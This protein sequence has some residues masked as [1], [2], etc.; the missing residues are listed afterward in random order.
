MARR[1]PW[2]FCLLGWSSPA[3]S[4]VAS[5]WRWIIRTWGSAGS[6][7]RRQLVGSPGFKCC[8]VML[9]M[10][11]SQIWKAWSE[12]VGFTLE[13]PGAR[14][15]TQVAGPPPGARVQEAWGGLRVSPP[16]RSRWCCG[17]RQVLGTVGRTAS[18]LAPAWRRGPHFVLVTADSPTSRPPVLLSWEIWALPLGVP[19][20]GT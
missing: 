19:T 2:R 8:R 4:S 6:V 1:A 12:A 9:T 11:V 5:Y 16:V 20:K 15:K 10:T 7:D 18:Q 17:R 13:P 14:V 3:S